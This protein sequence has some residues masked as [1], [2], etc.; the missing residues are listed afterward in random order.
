[1]FCSMRK[2]SGDGMRL[3]KSMCF[4]N[5]FWL[6]PSDQFNDLANVSPRITMVWPT[7]ECLSTTDNLG[8]F[9]I[10]FYI[11]YIYSK[12]GKSQFMLYVKNKQKNK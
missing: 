2:Y 11:S 3:Q 4:I 1:M 12:S 8:I 5:C 10:I 6:K 7:S 9:R